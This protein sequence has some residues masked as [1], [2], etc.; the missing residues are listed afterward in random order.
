MIRT[1]INRRHCFSAALT[2]TIAA[3]AFLACSE[4]TPPDES[5]TFFGPNVAMASGTVRSYITLDHDG[6]PIELGLAISE[7]AMNGLPA[8]S[9]EYVLALPSEA[10]AT[11]YKHAVINWQP[12]GHP[13]AMVYTVPHFDAHF[14]LISQAERDAIVL[15]DAQLAAKM[16]RQPGAEFVP[17]GYL[18]GMPS[19]QMGMHW[20]DPAAPERNGQPFTHTF[21]YGSYDGAFIFYEPMVTKAFLETKPVGVVTPIKLA[22]QFATHGYQATSYKVAYDPDAKEYHIALTALVLR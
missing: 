13:P 5:G 4:S 9:T 20:N 1:D 3:G 18:P 14:Y 11:A 2:V 10:S 12:T 16:I 8:G 19:T 22:T 17:P 6:T 7:N 15:G 21:I